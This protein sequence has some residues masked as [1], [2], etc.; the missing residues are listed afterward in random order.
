MRNINKG[1]ELTGKPGEYLIKNECVFNIGILPAQKCTEE[2]HECWLSKFKYLIPDCF[3]QCNCETCEKH[4]EVCCV[5][6]EEKCKV[7]CIMKLA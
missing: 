2:C 5:N 3:K 4:E 6:K 1:V 7:N